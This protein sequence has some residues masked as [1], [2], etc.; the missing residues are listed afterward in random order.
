[1]LDH[2]MRM[3]V[4]LFPLANAAALEM[5]RQDQSESTPVPAMWVADWADADVER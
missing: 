4:A 3:D 1:M 5:K 2:R